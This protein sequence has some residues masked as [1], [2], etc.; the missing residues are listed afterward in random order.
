[1][2]INEIFNIN[3]YEKRMKIGSYSC[4]LSTDNL[5][6][7]GFGN[8]KIH[9][10]ISHNSGGPYNSIFYCRRFILQWKYYDN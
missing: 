7:K 10:W 3:K 9:L 4:I 1:M 8:H 5:I 2:I 6:R